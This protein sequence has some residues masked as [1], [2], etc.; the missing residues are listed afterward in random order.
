MDLSLRS[1]A[2]ELGTSHRMLLYYFDSRETLLAKALDCIQDQVRTDLERAM[3]DAHGEVGRLG[4][5][6]ALVRFAASPEPAPYFR[7]LVESWSLVHHQP[8]VYGRFVDP[9]EVWLPAIEQALSDDGVP[10][11]RRTEA[12]TLVL[13]A[14]QGQLVARHLHHASLSVEDGFE[15]VWATLE[16]LAFGRD[17]VPL[18]E[19]C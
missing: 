5:T 4:R 16:R 9:R 19:H 1:M 7:L 10:A 6:K 13:S 3:I 8:E 12:A 14:L 2:T 11:Q 17:A 15:L 18:G